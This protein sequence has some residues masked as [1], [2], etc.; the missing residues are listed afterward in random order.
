MSQNQNNTIEQTALDRYNKR[1]DDDA[2]DAIKLAAITSRSP[3][4]A[5]FY[6]PQYSEVAELMNL[7]IDAALEQCGRVQYRG[8]RVKAVL[9]AASFDKRTLDALDTFLSAFHSTKSKSQTNS[10]GV[11]QQAG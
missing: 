10:G 1:Y 11:L 8:A 4:Y 9:C 6:T 3:Y 7:A 2:Y 5:G